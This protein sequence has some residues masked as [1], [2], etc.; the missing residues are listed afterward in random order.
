MG[1]VYKIMKAA[2]KVIEFRLAG[3]VLS[4]DIDECRII[5]EIDDEIHIFFIEWSER[6]FPDPKITKREFE[7][8]LIDFK[9]TFFDSDIENASIVPG[10]IAFWIHEDRAFV[11]VTRGVEL[12]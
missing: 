3:E 2:K 9:E 4:I 12:K 6:E 10:H 8:A 11:R 1:N 5:A 7:K